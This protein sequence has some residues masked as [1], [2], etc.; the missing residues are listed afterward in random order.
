MLLGGTL[1]TVLGL[2]AGTQAE[3]G[4]ETIG[5]LP[6][7]PVVPGRRPF[8][9]AGRTFGGGIPFAAAPALAVRNLPLGTTRFL[10]L[11][12]QNATSRSSSLGPID[13][14]LRS[15][16]RRPGLTAA[17]ETGA[18]A[19]ATL[20]AGLSEAAD[21]SAPYSIDHSIELRQRSCFVES[22]KSA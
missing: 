8:V 19:G 2:F 5:A 6:S 14:L 3:Q 7:E 18:M 10:E 11:Q 21:P 4:L 22:T 12:R 16:Q 20:G 17:G 9:E 1:G 15:A 13:L